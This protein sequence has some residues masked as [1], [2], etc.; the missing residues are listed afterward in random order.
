[1]NLENIAH[2]K[3]QT[4]KATYY[5]IAFIWSVQSWKIYK[6]RKYITSW[7]GRGKGKDG[8]RLLGQLGLLFTVMKMF[9]IVV[10]GVTHCE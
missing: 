4:W 2:E 10:M 9:L 8:D 1:M 5:M 6:D 3:S 7:L